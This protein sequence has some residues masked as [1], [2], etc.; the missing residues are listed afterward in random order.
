VS[1]P[2]YV[3]NNG[4]ATLS[5]VVSDDTAVTYVSI[6]WTGSTSGSAAMQLSGATWTFVFDPPQD[7]PAG[8]VTFTI[9]AQDAAGNLS[10]PAT[11]NV[12]TVP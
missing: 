5:A 9:Q 10:A 1:S 2:V 7:T 12:Q 6:A 3:M 8:T 11:V 4:T